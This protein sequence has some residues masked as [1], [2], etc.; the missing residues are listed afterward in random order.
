MLIVDSV[1]DSLSSL[2]LKRIFVDSVFAPLV[3]LIGLRAVL[4]LSGYVVTNLAFVFAALYLFGT[5]KLHSELSC[6]VQVMGAV[7]IVLRVVS[8]VVRAVVVSFYHKF[9]YLFF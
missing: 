9:F 2:S 8:R 4:V 5:M 1:S 3:P 7:R 6:E